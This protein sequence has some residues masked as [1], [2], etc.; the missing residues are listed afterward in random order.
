M[1]QNNEISP[2]KK[3]LPSSYADRLGEQYSS[4]IS[5]VH[6]KKLGQYFTPAKIAKF[7]AGFVQLN[8][9]DV[10]ILDP[11]CGTAI[12]SCSLVESLLSL[13]N[14]PAEIEL[15]AFEIDKNLLSY[16]ILSLEY[17]KKWA[18]KRGCNITYNVNNKDFILANSDTLENQNRQ[19]EYFDFIISNPPYFKIQKTDG[20]VAVSN[21]VV[22][23]QP[24]IYSIFMYTATNL[25]KKNGQFVFITPRSFTSG[26]YF[27]AFREQFFSSMQLNAVHIFDSRKNAFKR[28]AVLQENII[29]YASK[30]G[31]VN[32]PDKVV[33]SSSYGV[34]DLINCNKHVC[35]FDELFSKNSRQKILHLP[36]T[37]D[38]AEIVRIFRSWKG[39]LNSYN[40]QISTGPVVSFRAKKYITNN[41]NNG[42]IYAPLYQMINTAK[43]N[44]AWPV[45]K[46]DKEQYI[47]VC[48]ES[49]SL[50]IPNKNYIF[51]RRFSA[52][53]DKSR[54]IATPYFSNSVDSDVIG[55]ENHLNYIYR[56]NGF[57]ERNEIIGLSAILNSSLFDKYFRTFNGNINV[58]STE[59]REMPLPELN[60]IKE[61]GDAVILLNNFTQEIIDDLVKNFFQ[62]HGVKLKY[63]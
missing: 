20:R 31:A 16:T 32:K 50:L 57:L 22:Y 55:V 29:I 45:V 2:L 49:K 48:E 18:K 5:L 11:G 13:E 36:V 43:M 6:K 54:L 4:N 12:L 44:W 61:M 40:I 15:V 41:P 62:H 63:E 17:L 53:D 25:L 46:K 34:D 39:N 27:R 9:K 3:E 60:L 51:I 10:K 26:L 35:R 23:G 47:R 28:D 38:E 1:K 37:S 30:A 59:L 52:K 7:M 58:S 19:I 21:A 56:P 42:F 8:D 14:F 33:I 24:N